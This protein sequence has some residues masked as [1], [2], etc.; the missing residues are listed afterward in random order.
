MG[1]EGAYTTRAGS[2]FPPGATLRDGG[3][4]F[5]VFGRHASRVEL[6][7][8]DA[9]DTPEPFLVVALAPETNRSFRRAFF[10]AYR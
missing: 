1:A 8:F 7:L 2:R 5:C 6:L 9:P 4:N 3:V 10:P